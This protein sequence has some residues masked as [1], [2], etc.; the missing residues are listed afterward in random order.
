[1]GG[2]W[3]VVCWTGRVEIDGAFREFREFKEWG[4]MELVSLVKLPKFLK[5]P[6]VFFA[7]GVDWV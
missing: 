5:L 7:L 2:V 3:G 4:A 1:M 6:N